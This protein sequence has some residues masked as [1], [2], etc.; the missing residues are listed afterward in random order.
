[1]FEV[2]LQLMNSRPIDARNAEEDKGKEEEYTKMDAVPTQF[3]MTVETVGS[4]DAA[5]CFQQGIRVLQ[6]KVANIFEELTGATTQGAYTNGNAGGNDEYVPQ[7]PGEMAGGY[8]AYQGPGSQSAWGGAGY[9]TQYGT[10]PQY[11]GGGWQ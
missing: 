3:Y 7:S 8:T 4:L 9:Q 5:E 11:N 10:S 1:V 6:Q 2:K